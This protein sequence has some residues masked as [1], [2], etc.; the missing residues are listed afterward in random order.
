MTESQIPASDGANQPEAVDDA[1]RPSE[2]LP[3]RSRPGYRSPEPGW[4]QKLG[5][6][7]PLVAAMLR[8]TV[9]LVAFVG[10]MLA[11][12]VHIATPFLVGMSLLM[13]VGGVVATLKVTRQEP[14]LRP[15]GR[16]FAAVA[17]GIVVVAFAIAAA[18]GVG[19]FAPRIEFGPPRPAP[20]PVDDGT[21]RFESAP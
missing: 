9:G 12:P 14:A 7:S 4:S 21:I 17:A 11:M 20:P 13:V 5:E 16:I 15:V 6:W 19:A 8:S 10:V 18:V 1:A 3:R 2:I